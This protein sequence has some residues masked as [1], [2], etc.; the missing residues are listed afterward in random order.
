MY[1]L[2]LNCSELEK[3]QSKQ[4]NKKN[5]KTTKHP[6][7]ILKP[8]PWQNSSLS[9]AYEYFESCVKESSDEIGRHEQYLLIFYPLFNTTLI[10]S[11]LL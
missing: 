11:W 3:K 4:Q 1:S 9:P 2:F 6:D 10:A 7:F 5:K 8:P